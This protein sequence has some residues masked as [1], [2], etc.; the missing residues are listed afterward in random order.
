LLD[1]VADTFGH[2]TFSTLAVVPEVG[3]EVGV[4]A[5]RVNRD[6]YSSECIFDVIHFVC[7]L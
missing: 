2:W 5:G 4:S 7:A 6:Q 1:P 3:A